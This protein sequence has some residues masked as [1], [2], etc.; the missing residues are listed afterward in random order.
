M[1][2]DASGEAVRTARAPVAGGLAAALFE[3][4]QL[5]PS[6]LY[7]L[8]FI[9][10][11]VECVVI[12]SVLMKA[13]D[14]GPSSV[15]TMGL[16]LVVLCLII[17]LLLLRTR[18]EG[19]TVYVALGWV[20]VL[21]RRIP[22]DEVLECR[23]VTYHPIRDAGGWGLRFGRFEGQPCRFWNA[24]GNEGVLIV[25]PQR[26]Y[27]IGTQRPEDLLTAIR[28]VSGNGHAARPKPVV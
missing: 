11:A 14:E 19:R 16:V 17:N 24:R 4:T 3:E 15:L 12:G 8:L 1:S 10:T 25:T 23:A 13:G 20:P 26:R 18:V 5:F 7:V 27:I 21:W 6:F 22:L 9:I 28:T 2:L